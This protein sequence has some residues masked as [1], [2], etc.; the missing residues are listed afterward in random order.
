MMITDID[1]P[2]TPYGEDSAWW[3]PLYFKIEQRATTLDRL[4]AYQDR[5]EAEQES[6]LTEIVEEFENE[7]V[8]ADRGIVTYDMLRSGVPI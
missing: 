2:V 6:R 8:T 3:L 5:Q 7:L 1:F 4:L